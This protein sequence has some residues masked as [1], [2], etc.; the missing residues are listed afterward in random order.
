MKEERVAASKRPQGPEVQAS[1][2]TKKKLIEAIHDAL[3]CSKICSYAQ[4]FQLMG[5]AQ[6]EYNWKLNFGEIAQ[7]WRGGCIIR[8]R[9]LQKI[10]E[11]YDRDPN[12]ANLLLDPYFQQHDAEGAGEL[13]QGRGAGGEAACRPGVH[14]GP[15][16]L[17]R[18]PRRGAAGEPAAGPAR[19]LRRAHLRARR[20]ASREVLPH[21][22]AGAE[23]A[24]VDDWKII[25]S[26]DSAMRCLAA[27]ASP[28]ATSRRR[29]KAATC[30]PT[31]WG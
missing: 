22:L 29:G 27:I 10:T 20:P 12:L 9:F 17:R 6:K 21:R 7:I 24:A 3:Y 1:T 28:S 15:G 5:E 14:V 25:H 8:A 18:L 26:S 11:A 31:R 4:G 13:A 30:F 16:V 23:A 2:A 19:L